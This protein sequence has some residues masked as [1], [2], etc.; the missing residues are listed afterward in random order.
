M[1]LAGEISASALAFGFVGFYPMAMQRRCNAADFLTRQ[2][3]T[4]TTDIIGPTNRTDFSFLVNETPDIAYFYLQ[5]T[6]GLSE[7]SMWKITFYSGSILGMTP[8]NLDNKVSLLKRMMDLSDDDVR[9]MVTKQPA[10]LQYSAQRNL[11]PTILFLVRSL[12]MS[13]KELRTLLLDSPS[14]LGYSLSNLKRKISFFFNLYGGSDGVDSD[15]V[16]KLLLG[17]PKLLLAGVDT[18]LRPRVD[19]LHREMQF[20]RDELQR[21]FLRNPLILLYSVEENIKNKVSRILSRTNVGADSIVFS[22]LCRRLYFSS[23]CS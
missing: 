6:L 5:N 20:S 19:F 16:R 12:E 14:I 9:V 17:T 8:R 23:F 10:I 4:S 13:K 15:S 21:L 1:I 7:E 22:L 3:G 2:M 18:G 11:A